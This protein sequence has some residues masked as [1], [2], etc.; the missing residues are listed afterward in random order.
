LNPEDPLIRREGLQEGPLRPAVQLFLRETLLLP[1]C[2]FQSPVK[3]L[4]I[5]IRPPAR[6]VEKSPVSDATRAAM[7]RQGRHPV[8]RC[9]TIRRLS[10]FEDFRARNYRNSSSET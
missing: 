8:R 1:A 4:L 2:E 9:P 10:F 7:S 5:D 3:D 6:P